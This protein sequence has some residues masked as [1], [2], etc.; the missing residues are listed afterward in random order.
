MP[1]SHY[2][3]PKTQIAMNDYKKL[4]VWELAMEC[5][6]DIYR[7]TKQFPTDERFG[8]VSQMNRA[9]VSIASNIAEGAGRNSAREFIQF[10]GYASGSLAELE[11]QVIICERV[12]LII[13]ED[14]AVLKEKLV[15]MHKQIYALMKSLEAGA[16]SKRY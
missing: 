5:V 10:L 13:Q 7:M 9:A 14:A 2:P 12:E 6:L 4:A 8:L 16:A 15:R 11:T 3:L 1:L